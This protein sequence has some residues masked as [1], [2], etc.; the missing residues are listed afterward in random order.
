MRKVEASDGLKYRV[1]NNGLSKWLT[2][3]CGHSL[4]LDDVFVPDVTVEVECDDVVVI[5]ED[6]D[7]TEGVSVSGTISI[8]VHAEARSDRS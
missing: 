8:D 5:V 2:V 7:V 1:S 6:T 3:S 4:S